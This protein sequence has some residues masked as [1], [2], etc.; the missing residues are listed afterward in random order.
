MRAWFFVVPVIA[1]ISPSKNSPFV[2][3]ARSMARYP[4]AVRAVLGSALLFWEAHSYLGQTYSRKPGRAKVGG[5]APDK[6]DEQELHRGS[7]AS[8]NRSPTQAQ[9]GKCPV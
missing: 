6:E 3:A 5:P 9:A 4:A 8:L 7:G 1:N 2:S